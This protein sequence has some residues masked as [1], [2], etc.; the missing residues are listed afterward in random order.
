[1]EPVLFSIGYFYFHYG[2]CQSV[3]LSQRTEHLEAARHAVARFDILLGFAG[4]RFL[5]VQ[6]R[7]RLVLVDSE[8]VPADLPVILF[9][10]LDARTGKSEGKGFLTNFE[11]WLYS[12]S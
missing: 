6:G 7:L 8:P 1:M 12:R 2:L 3:R 9:A 11:Q 10:G 5:D 4:D